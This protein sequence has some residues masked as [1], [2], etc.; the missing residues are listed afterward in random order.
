M[1]PPLAVPAFAPPKNTASTST[2][3]PSSTVT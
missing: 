3:A 1:A 2:A